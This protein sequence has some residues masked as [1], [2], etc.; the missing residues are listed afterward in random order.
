MDPMRKGPEE[1]S[2]AKER[3]AANDPHL[4]DGRQPIGRTGADTAMGGNGPGKSRMKGRTIWLVVLGVF[5]VGG[6]V[7]AWQWW[8]SRQQQL[9]A[10][11][12]SGNGRIEADEVDVATKYVGRVQE[13]LVNEGDLVQPGQLLVQMDTAE[14]Q[15]SLERAKAELARAEAEIHELRADARHKARHFL[16]LN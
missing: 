16:R 11:I 15:A 14:L 6:L 9:P 8:Q 3:P 2:A 12:V 5:L 4:V 7:A 13:L 10:G 1:R